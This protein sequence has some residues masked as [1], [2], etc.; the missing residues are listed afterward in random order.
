MAAHRDEIAPGVPVVWCCT[1]TSTL[2]T[3]NIPSDMPG[4]VVQYDWTGTFALAERL[5]PDAKTLVIVS[6]AAEIDR[7]WLQDAI[8]HLRPF[9]KKYDARYV[10]SRKQAEIIK[11]VSRLPRNSI[12]MLMPI[13]GIDAARTGPSDRAI[14]FAKASPAPTYSPAAT[15]FGDGIVGGTMD[16]Y[17]GQGVAIADLAIAVLSGK[18]PSTLPHR[19]TLPLQT[20]VDARQLEHWGF[21]E[22]SLPPGTAVEFRRPTVW[23]QYRKTIIGV[24]LAF[25]VQGGIIAL[26]LIQKHK[27]RAA[28]R[29]L[30]ESEDRMTFAAAST[31]IGL[32][33]LDVPSERLWAT[34]HCR[35]MFGI[36]AGDTISWELLREAVHPD[37]RQTFDE[38]V[39]LPE[40]IGHS[41]PPVEF[42]I[43]LPESGTRWY[44]TRHYTVFGDD[45]K[46]LQ[47]SGIFVDVTA[48]KSAEA[49]SELQRKELTHMLRVAAMG[50]LSGGIAH[51]LSQPLAAIL[52]NAQAAQAALA[53]KNHNPDEIAEILEDIVQEDNRAGQVIHRLRQLL[54][55]GEHQAGFVSLN[56]LVKSTLGLLHSELVNRKIKVD[57]DLRRDLPL[58]QGD[59]VQLQQ[60]LLNLMMNAMEA[61]ASTRASHRTLSIGTRETEGCVEI[62]IRDRGPGMSPEE[63]QRLFEPFF[64]TKERGL[65]LG[66]SICSTIVKSHRGRLNLSNASTGG[67]AAIVSLPVAVQMAEAS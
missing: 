67:A 11:E 13:F 31:N 60:V 32:W 7:V 44:L 43:V 41:M 3:L 26:L 40:R 25:A 45:G 51:E 34:K 46:P 48:R 54:K 62:S 22:A 63:L 57:M 47:V 35:S 50:E 64:T 8:S 2:E 4:V 42:R 29:L 66:L 55:K 36:A 53:K 59:S 39:Q 28:E 9:L 23:E 21:S 33:W 18:D 15:L 17:V 30:K 16:S 38:G 27:R 1:P 19:A 14:N 58:V 10:V 56:D 61:M 24:L 52:A 20:R 6:G 5:Q 12:V 37:D 49:E 65:G